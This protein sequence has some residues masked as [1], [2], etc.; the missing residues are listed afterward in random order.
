M[1]KYLL[2]WVLGVPTV[3]LVRRRLGPAEI[4]GRVFDCAP[5]RIDARHLAHSSAPA[6][7][8]GV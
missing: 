4:L 2:G 3:V 5:D 8:A 7:V 6:V 1:G